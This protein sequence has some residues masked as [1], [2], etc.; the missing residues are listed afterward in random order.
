[1]Q[2]HDGYWI[3]GTAVAGP[4]YTNYWTPGGAVLFQRT[5]GSVVELVRFTLHSFELDDQDVAALFGVEL[6]RLVVDRCYA[7]LMRQR[8]DVEQ[9]TTKPPHRR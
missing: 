1:M 3:S 8:Q 7:E 5:N 9:R 4:P 6:A 2:K